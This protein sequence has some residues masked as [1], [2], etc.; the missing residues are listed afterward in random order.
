MAKKGKNSTSNNI[1][2]FTQKV[3]EMTI[4]RNGKR[5]VWDSKKGD[6]VPKSKKK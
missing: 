6:F 1:G 3:E 4:I 2:R 5:M